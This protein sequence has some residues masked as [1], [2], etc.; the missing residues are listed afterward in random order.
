MVNRGSLI[1]GLCMFKY[2]S[3]EKQEK[4]FWFFVWAINEIFLE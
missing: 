4:K 1:S 3:F 2:P